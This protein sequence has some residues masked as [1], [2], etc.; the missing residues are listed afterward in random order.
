MNSFVQFDHQDGKRY[1][2]AYK[3]G[4]GAVGSTG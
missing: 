3:P 4:T 2:L 1:Q